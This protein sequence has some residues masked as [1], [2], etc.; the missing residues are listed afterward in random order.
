MNIIIKSFFDE[1][2]ICILILM[3]IIIKSFFDETKIII[4]QFKF[5]FKKL[6]LPACNSSSSSSSIK[7]N[8]N[9]ITPTIRGYILRQLFHQCISH[10]SNVLS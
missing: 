5:W 10:E 4:M 6:I 1:T 2:K 9:I 8:V 3:N 7:F